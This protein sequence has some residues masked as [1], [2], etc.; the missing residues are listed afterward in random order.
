MPYARKRDNCENI[1]EIVGD[2]GKIQ[3]GDENAFNGNT[4]IFAIYCM[5]V[6]KKK[7]NSDAHVSVVETFIESE[8]DEIIKTK[9]TFCALFAS[10]LRKLILNSIWKYRRSFTL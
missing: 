6:K 8:N 1:D 9:C 10:K 5:R 7:K 3:Y 2:D 4:S